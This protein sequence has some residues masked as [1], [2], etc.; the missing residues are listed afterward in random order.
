GEP[1]L[2]GKLKVSLTPG[3]LASHI[4]GRTSTDEEFHCNYALNPEFQPLFDRASL[5]IVGRGP[6]GEARVVELAGADFFIATLFL[7][8]M[9]PL[10]SDPHPLIGALFAQVLRSK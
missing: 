9:S 2:D 10:H 8:Q 4:Y 3:S 1:R 6:E 7:P 5:R